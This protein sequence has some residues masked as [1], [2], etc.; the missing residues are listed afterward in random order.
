MEGEHAVVLAR[1][2]TIHCHPC[3]QGCRKAKVG[4][5]QRGGGSVRGKKGRDDRQNATHLHGRRC[6]F[7]FTLAFFKVINLEIPEFGYALQ[8]TSLTE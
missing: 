5:A 1:G 3:S 6:A 8:G 4:A 2:P 7:F